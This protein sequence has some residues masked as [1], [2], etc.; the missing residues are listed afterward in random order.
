MTRHALALWRLP[1]T[2]HRHRFLLR[3]LAWRA[4]AARHAGSAGAPVRV[5][6]VSTVTPTYPNTI[7][8]PNHHYVV[9]VMGYR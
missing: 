2:L 9:R 5:S 1:G 7:I 6:G 3:Q 8:D 4:F